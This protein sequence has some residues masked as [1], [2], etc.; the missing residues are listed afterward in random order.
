[1][2][3]IAATLADEQA[4]Y[5]TAAYIGTSSSVPTMILHHWFFKVAIEAIFT[6]VTYLIVG[7][8]KR[9]EGIDTYDRDTKYNPFTL[10]EKEQV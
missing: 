9:K 10:Y 4:M 5:D 2:A 7:W 3:A 8:L 6:P 1:M